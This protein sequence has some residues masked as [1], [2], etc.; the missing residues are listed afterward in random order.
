M[1]RMSGGAKR[2]CDRAL[3]NLPPHAPAADDERVVA[4]GQDLRGLHRRDFPRVG[5]VVA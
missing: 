1:Q 3:G 2:Q 4:R 5:L